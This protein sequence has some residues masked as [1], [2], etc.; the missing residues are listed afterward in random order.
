M[1]LQLVLRRSLSHA[2]SPHPFAHPRSSTARCSAL[3]MASQRPFS[4]S[5]STSPPS[6]QDSQPADAAA[7]SSSSKPSALPAPGEG[8]S[9]NP[10]ILDV[11]GDGTTV[12]LDALGPLVVNQDGSMARI[13]NWDKMAD[14]EK[15]NAL[16]IIGKRNQIRLAALR[17]AQG[18]DA[19]SHSLGTNINQSSDSS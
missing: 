19:G 17:K 1:H 3:Q 4:S 5:S 12:K 15:Q 11:S 6:P 9:D 14:I 13:S 8:T 2:R 18:I 10:T 16:R 7:P